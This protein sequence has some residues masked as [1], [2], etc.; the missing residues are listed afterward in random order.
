MR[1][2]ICAKLM[3][4]R[5]SERIIYTLGRD[6]L[7]RLRTYIS[8]L[9]AHEKKLKLAQGQQHQFKKRLTFREMGSAE[10][11]LKV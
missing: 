1:K 9:N 7:K 6:L 5:T 3:S 11:L 2:E 4:E 8:M 10:Q